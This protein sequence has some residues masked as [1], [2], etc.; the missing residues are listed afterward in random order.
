LWQVG[1]GRL[2]GAGGYIAELVSVFV[3]DAK[4]GGAQAGVDAEYFH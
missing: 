3:N 2:D 4:T 1:I